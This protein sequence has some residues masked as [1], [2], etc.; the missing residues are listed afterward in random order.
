MTG[1]NSFHQK[2]RWRVRLMAL[3][4]VGLLAFLALALWHIQV[5]ATAR[6][7]EDL[8]R[9]SVRRIRLPGPRGRIFD[10]QRR[11]LADNRPNYQL[12]LFLEE[13]RRP[14]SWERTIDA[15]ESLL[16]EV[17]LEL[18]QPVTLDREAIRRHVRYGLPLPLIAW[19][20]LDDVTLAR[21]AELTAGRP[22]IDLII[23][24][25]RVYPEG[26]TGAHLLGYVGRA[27]LPDEARSTYHQYIPEVKGR[28]GLEQRF[29]A[30]LRG[31]PGGRLVRVD[32][33]G[34]RRRDL[35]GRAPQPGR[36]LLL[37]LD[38]DLQREAQQ[39]LAGHRGAL[40]VLDPRNGDVILLV[41]SPS[42]DLNEF[43]PSISRVAWGR[44]R[45]DTA[46]PMINRALAG[47][48]PPGSVFKPVV[49]LAAMQHA[50][51]H[52]G[53]V[54]SCAGS[55]SVGSRTFSCW[56]RSGHGALDMRQSL[57]HSCNV[58]Y[59]RLAL[60]M[61]VD[62]VVAMAEALG[63][64]RPTG[65][66]CD[67]ERGGILPS[68]AWKRRTRNEGWWD[69][70]TANLSI[71]QGY[72]LTTP[73]QMA[74][75][76]AAIANGGVRYRPRILMGMKA[77]EE[78]RFHMRPPAEAYPLGWDQEVVEAVRSGMRSAV[79]EATGTGRNAR[80]PGWS[81]AGKTGTAEYGPKG[82]GLNYA[83]MLAFAPVEAPR[84]AMALVIEEGVSGGQTA[85]PLVRRM[86]QV[87]YDAE[88]H[89]G[90]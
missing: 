31:E 20:D 56:Y 8:I 17:A 42:Y 39:L 4:Q 55:W 24:P 52:A 61:G 27:D 60:E 46:L 21:W 45:D 44:L 9:Q 57:Q 48:Y 62:P 3:A 75:V 89:A 90:G 6:Y 47:Q 59:F 49:A 11:I 43:I 35:G 71:G 12:G 53:R 80:I 26:R 69:G 18:D 88:E 22:G 51:V 70:D 50:G 32:V 54:I 23:E 79:M 16:Q 14:G 2:G 34:V 83:W 37:T 40:V 64:G 33:S 5:R 30:W 87:L 7:E 63:L 73:L 25:V 72:L 78:E 28:S 82:A 84:Y 36:D 29:D 85:A 86:L 76:T 38:R 13:L 68:P 58:Y 19:R 15:A 67:F 41:S 1:W 77:M 65:M 10:R 74:V 81:V 66:E